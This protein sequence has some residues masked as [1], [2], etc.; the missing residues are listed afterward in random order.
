MNRVQ[1]FKLQISFRRTEDDGPV[2]QKQDGERFDSNIT[3]K[4]NVNTKYSVSLTARPARPV[5]VVSVWCHRDLRQ[6][7]YIGH[8]IVT[9]SITLT[10]VRWTALREMSSPSF[11]EFPI[12]RREAMI[13]R[14]HDMIE[15]REP[16]KRGRYR[17]EEIRGELEDLSKF[18]IIVAMPEMALGQFIS[19]L[20]LKMSLSWGSLTFYTH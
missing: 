19:I 18:V 10:S 2:F 4:F 13:V 3:V 1:N 17:V 6:V 8:F 20:C 5:N 16:G 9:F 15:K 12:L 7:D 11:Y 14:R